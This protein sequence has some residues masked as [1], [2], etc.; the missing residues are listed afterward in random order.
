MNFSELLKTAIN[1]SI[2]GGHAIM[3]VY[4]S[5]FAIEHKADKSPLT[6][7]DKNCNAVIDSFLKK[8]NLPILSEEGRNILFRKKNGI[9]F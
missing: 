2:K 3:N 7:A 1:A 9:F 5:D 6:L 8:T 4:D